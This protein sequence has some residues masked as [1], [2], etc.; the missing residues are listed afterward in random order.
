[1][2]LAETKSLLS[3]SQRDVQ[4]LQQ[5]QEKSAKIERSYML[6]LQKQK[7]CIE[8]YSEEKEQ[9]VHTVND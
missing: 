7:A 4:L 5:K 9:L 8:Q 2:K 1:M 3:N 6:K